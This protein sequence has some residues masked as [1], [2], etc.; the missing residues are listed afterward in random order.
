MLR[1]LQETQLLHLAD[2]RRLLT[3]L[4]H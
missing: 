1:K 4:R 2:R 3:E